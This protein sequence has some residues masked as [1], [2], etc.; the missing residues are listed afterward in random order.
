[1][2]N[3]DP[4]QAVVHSTVNRRVKPLFKLQTYHFSCYNLQNHPLKTTLTKMIS[5]K[6]PS[7]FAY[8]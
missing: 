7:D 4:M 8:F 5:K 2:I 6:A 3:C 1:M